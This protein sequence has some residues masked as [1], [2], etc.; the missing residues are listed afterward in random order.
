MGIVVISA[1]TTVPDCLSSIL[2]A[3]KGEGDMAVCNA[4]G[5]PLMTSSCIVAMSTCAADLLGCM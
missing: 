1:G 5:V 3:K 4:I 2:V